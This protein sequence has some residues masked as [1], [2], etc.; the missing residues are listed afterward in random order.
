M[1]FLPTVTALD[2]FSCEVDLIH[3]DTQEPLRDPIRDTLCKHTHYNLVVRQCMEVCHTKRH[4]QSGACPRCPIAV[5]VP[6]NVSGAMPGRHPCP[7]RVCELSRTNSYRAPSGRKP[8]ITI[9][10]RKLH[11]RRLFQLLWA[12]TSHTPLRVDQHA[13]TGRRRQSNF[14]SNR[15]R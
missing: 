9:G 8:S 11:P 5:L 3:P 10:H 7:L 2:M 14:H 13:P 12:G 4:F 6:T 15:V 1:D